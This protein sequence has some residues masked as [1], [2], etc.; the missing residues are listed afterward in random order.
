MTSGFVPPPYPHDRLGEIK[1][2]PIEAGLE[3]VDL[4]I[5]TPIDPLPDFVGELSSQLVSARGYPSS[6]GSADLRDACLKWN[7]ERLGV[8]LEANQL[9]ACVGLKEFVA[10]TPNYLRLRTPDRDVVLYPQVSYPT[11][12]MGA[13]LGGCTPIAVPLLPSGEL[14]LGAIDEA[15]LERTL[16]LWVNSPSNPAGAV[17]D[18]SRAVAIGRRF[19]F[20]VISDEC[21]VE[22]TWDGP[23]RTILEHGTQDLLAIHSLSKRSNFAGGRVG[24]YAGDA[25]LVEYLAE[26]RKHGGLMIP[27]PMQAIATKLL[28]DQVHVNHQANIYR[29]RLMILLEIV[30]R[31]G[32]LATFPQGGFY[33]WLHGQDNEDGFAIAA[34]FAKAT[35]IIGSPGEFYGQSSRNYL[36]LAAVA[37]TQTLFGILERLR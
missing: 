26:V 1:K 11:Y 3:V 16:C 5:G 36:R 35:G 2:L 29:E 24:F 8:E 20:V 33:I 12:A 6:I 23:P 27:G 17:S 28:G 18:L 19:G 4:S 34:A 7:Y 10:S 37:P 21:Y 13:L 22:F 14:N 25:T 15:I 32:Y 9:A 30:E 31:L